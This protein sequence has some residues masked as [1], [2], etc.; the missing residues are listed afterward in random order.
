[1]TEENTPVALSDNK[2][3]LNPPGDPYDLIESSDP[4]LK[5]VLLP[6]DF[7]NAPVNPIDFSYDLVKSMK[8]ERGLGL[9]ANQLGFPYRVFCME[10]SPVLVCYNPKIV[11]VSDEQI[12]LEE[13]CLSFPNL[14]VKIKRPRS[15]RARFT[16]PNG[17]TVTMNFND[18]TARIYQ[19]EM[20]HLNGIIFYSR[21]SIIER[22]RAF[23]HKKKLDRN[24]KRNKNL[25]K[26]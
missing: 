14:F 21:A 13:G 18:M 4:I 10:T 8:I 22:R 24:A 11:N 1:M 15:I 3:F 16:Y 6:F 5:E 9:S 20:D 7:V 23:D 25:S 26:R 12:I 17:Q 2:V 19:H